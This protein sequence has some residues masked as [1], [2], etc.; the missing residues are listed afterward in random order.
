M[1]GRCVTYSPTAPT[2]TQSKNLANAIKKLGCGMDT[3]SII[4]ESEWQHKGNSNIKDSVIAQTSPM[5]FAFMKVGS[6]F[7]QLVHSVGKLGGDLF[8]PAKYQG[9]VICFGGIGS[10]V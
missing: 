8:T 4:K 6:L 3:A 7:I 10:R 5:V 1:K 2:A 9:C